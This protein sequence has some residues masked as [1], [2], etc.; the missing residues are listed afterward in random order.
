MKRQPIML[1]AATLALVMFWMGC[2]LNIISPL[3]MDISRSYRV[4]VATAGWL[5]TSF[6]AGYAIASPM[7]GWFSDRFGR[8]PTLAVSMGVFVIFEVL[9]GVAPNMATALAARS[10]TGISAGGVSPIAYAMVGDWVKKQDRSGVMSILSIGFS[11]STVAGVPLG[12]WLAS[13]IGWRGTL[14]AIGVALCFAGAGLLIIVR[15]FPRVRSHSVRRQSTLISVIESTWPQLTASFTAFAAAGLVYTYLPTSLVRRGIP[16]TWWLM[17]ILAGYGLF[18]LAGNLVF[19]RAGNR[20]GPRRT[21]LVA[22]I[23]EFASVGG[24]LVSAL[25]LSAVF[26]I[27]SSWI[28]AFC[29]AYIPDLKALAADV[30]M[31]WRGSS[32]A[33]NNTAMYAGMTIGSALGT[34]L[35]RPG[36]FWVLAMVAGGAIIIGFSTMAWLGLRD[37]QKIRPVQFD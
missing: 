32:L 13:A 21:V 7:A 26:L 31:H 16:H 36:T 27:V 3:L 2:D 25:Y 18:N 35:Y 6:A 23:L 29:Q 8:L 4:S 11:L 20:I 9:S 15:K 12:L 34:R 30:P 28:F 17:L 5:I 37:R 22:Q 24:I 19:G 10:L 1:L 33:L 14:I